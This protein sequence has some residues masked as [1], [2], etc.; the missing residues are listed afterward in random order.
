MVLI[1]KNVTL[2]NVVKKDNK[3][4][5][6]TAMEALTAFLDLLRVKGDEPF[7][8]TSLVPKSKYYAGEDS[9]KTFSIHYC[10]A[11]KKESKLTLTDKPGPYSPLR[12]DI[13]LKASLDQGLKR[14]YTPELVKKIIGFYQ[15]EIRAAVPADKLEPKHLWCILLEKKAPRV[16]E[17]IVKDG[18]HLHFPYFICEGWFYDEYLREKVT[19]KMVEGKVWDG[20]N[21]LDPVSKFIDT[22][23]SKKM[24]LMYGSA[25]NLTT[26]PFLFSKAFDGGLK[27]MKLETIFAEK[28]EGKK[29]SVA[30]YL[31]IFL[32]V[33]GY[34]TCVPLKP[35]VDAKKGLSSK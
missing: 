16:D 33:R 22:G 23:M 28:M 21:Y 3:K 18:L 15:D 10:N 13:D 7:T 9:L 25:K 34:L 11:V 35:E 6:R 27:E 31:P 14:Q 24:W 5:A 1:T 4:P 30:Y 20:C 29:S 17:T 32:T 12:V 19:N 8:H 26:T 2:K